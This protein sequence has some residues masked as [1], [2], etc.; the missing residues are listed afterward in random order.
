MPQFI[1]TC[2]HTPSPYIFSIVY[3]RKQ[4]AYNQPYTTN[5]GTVWRQSKYTLSKYAYSQSILNHICIKNEYC[6]S[7]HSLTGI[8]QHNCL[9]VLTQSEKNQQTVWIQSGIHLY[10]VCILFEMIKNLPVVK[11]TYIQNCLCLY[12][13]DTVWIRVSMQFGYSIHAV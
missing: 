4:S 7:S 12:L 8:I 3:I 6:F 1:Y 11:F 9:R 13:L 5:Q 2:V 10:T